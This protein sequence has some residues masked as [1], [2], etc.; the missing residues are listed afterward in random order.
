VLPQI[1]DAVMKAKKAYFPSIPG[2]VLDNLKSNAQASRAIFASLEAMEKS[3][4]SSETGLRLLIKIVEAARNLS[5][6]DAL[7]T[8]LRSSGLNPDTVTSLTALIVKLGRYSTAA[9]FLVRAAEELSIFTQIEI[10]VI[11][12]SSTS[13]LLIAE[14]QTFVQGVL[15]GIFNASEA[16]NAAVDITA[17]LEQKY[18]RKVVLSDISSTKF[19]V[20]AEIQLLFY[21]EL[22]P[23][24]LAPRLIC[25]SKMACFLCNLFVKLHGKFI[26]PSSHGKLYEKWTLP[27]KINELQGK[28]AQR[29]GVVMDRFSDVVGDEL[30]IEVQSARQPYPSPLE[31]AIFASA[32]WSSPHRSQTTSPST[33]SQATTTAK[34]RSLLQDQPTLYHDYHQDTR[35]AQVDVVTPL[36]QGSEDMS[37]GPLKN[38][39]PST[40]DT[41]EDLMS[42][43]LVAEGS[44]ATLKEKSTHSSRTYFPL[45]RGELL[46]EE[47]SDTREFLKVATP[48]IHLTLSF[49][50]W[51]ESMIN[52]IRGAG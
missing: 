4:A 26:I 27:E 42:T 18:S 14:P 21:Y 17:R 34:P 37:G 19:V 13:D 10:S 23:T 5:S 32:V 51:K 35:D 30:R 6:K 44:K 24:A 7:G 15:N 3:D 31:S 25:S 38:A 43:P 29:I 33:V 22:Q 9:S 8:I 46:V 2:T 20:H 36:H 1:A 11:K 16:E 52:L 41:R 40:S 45:T 28:Q 47:L 49:D 50:W 48:R 39:Q 12:L